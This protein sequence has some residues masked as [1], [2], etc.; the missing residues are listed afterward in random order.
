MVPVEIFDFAP[1]GVTLTPAQDADFDAR[2]AAL[3]AGHASPALDL[4]P[5]L[6]IVSNRGPRTVVAYTVSWTAHMRNLSSETSYSQFTFPDAVAGTGSGLSV[7]RGREI[8][9]GEERL[10]GMGFEVWPL[11][12]VESYRIFGR[13]AAERLGDVTG[14]TIALDAVLFDDGVMLGPDESHLAEHFIAFVQAKQTLYR[15][16]VVALERGGAR[17]D[18]FAPLRHTLS[19][20]APHDP[21]DSRAIYGRQAAAEVLGFHDRIVLEVFR[22]TLRRE[23]FSIQRTAPE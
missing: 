20:R 10:V 11:E 6:A 9:V 22:R 7:L 12:Y 16:I 8:H 5:Y 3:L 13:S 2:V 15:D 14:L 1:E 4:K 18:V 19:T 17:D 21:A 23:P